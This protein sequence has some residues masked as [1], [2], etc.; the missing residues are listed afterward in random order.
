MLLVL[1]GLD[2]GEI[3]RLRARKKELEE[4]I[5]TLEANIKSLQ[6]QQRKFEDE[7]AKLRKQRV[8]KPA[9]FLNILTICC[10][11]V[12]LFVL[13]SNSFSSFIIG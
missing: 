11:Y 13:D 10:I 4:S 5:Y 7:A 1:L 12:Q 3:E 2:A 8:F 9:S 6:L